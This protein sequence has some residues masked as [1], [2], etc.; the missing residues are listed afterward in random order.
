VCQIIGNK[1]AALYF[2][3]GSGVRQAKSASTS[4]SGGRTW[5]NQI[6]VTAIR[7]KQTPAAVSP[8]SF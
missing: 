5:A 1:R 7:E 2:L 6:E 4:G 3:P 8:E